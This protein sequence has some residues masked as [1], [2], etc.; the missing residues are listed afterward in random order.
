M[1]GC[2]EL[3]RSLPAVDRVLREEVLQCLV[4]L[5]PQEA[6]SGAVQDVLT[7]LRQEILAK[8]QLSVPEK[9]DVDRVAAAAA[10]RCR[11]LLQPSLRKVINATGTL[12]HT[13]LGRAP[14]SEQVLNRFSLFLRAIPTLNLISTAVSVVIATA[15]SNRS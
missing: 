4:D 6:I 8:G 12:L 2:Q 11:A 9:I 13:N 5:L 10:G 1:S 7:E 15:M 14:L 3:L